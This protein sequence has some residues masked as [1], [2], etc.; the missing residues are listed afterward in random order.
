MDEDKKEGDQGMDLP[1]AGTFVGPGTRSSRD[2][3]DEWLDDSE[4]N[5]SLS[6]DWGSTSPSTLIF[7]WTADSAGLSSASQDWAVD[8]KVRSSSC[9]RD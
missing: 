3:R 4:G 5:L 7:S 6:P 9:K 8:I 1:V 2:K